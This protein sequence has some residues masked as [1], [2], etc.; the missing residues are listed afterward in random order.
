MLDGYISA[1]LSLHLSFPLHLSLPFLPLTAVLFA[2]LW[3]R[4]AATTATTHSAA[5]NTRHEG[6]SESL[7]GMVGNWWKARNG[8]ACKSEMEIRS[9]HQPRRC[10]KAMFHPCRP[11]FDAPPHVISKEPIVFFLPKRAPRSQIWRMF[12]TSSV[13]ASVRITQVG[14]S[15]KNNNGLYRV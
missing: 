1:S 7:T 13:A 11:V 3:L 12:E 8:R 9:P 14:K 5:L 4:T 10:A 2:H 15:T 6:I